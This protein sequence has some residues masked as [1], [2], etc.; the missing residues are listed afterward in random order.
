MAESDYEQQQE[1]AA[2]Q[3]D[4]EREQEALAAAEAAAIGGRVSSEPAGSSDEDDEIDPA[5]VPLRE[6]GQGESEGFEDAERELIERASHGDEHAARRVLED[7][8]GPEENDRAGRYGEADS[9]GAQ[10]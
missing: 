4:Y 8:P 10:E 1:Q 6:A 9:A 2:E 3:A 5:Q 7:A